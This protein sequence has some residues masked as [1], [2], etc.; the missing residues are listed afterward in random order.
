M[1]TTTYQVIMCFFRS[2]NCK[3]DFA[4]FQF[5]Y[6]P[7]YSFFFFIIN[8]I[9][10]HPP[11][12]SHYMRRKLCVP[13]AIWDNRKFNSIYFLRRELIYIFRREVSVCITKWRLIEW[14]FFFGFQFIHHIDKQMSLWTKNVERPHQ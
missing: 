13:Y 1:I 3:G 12:C 8:V 4:T 9:F 11:W 2:T 5:V 10:W 6:L 14:F 7:F